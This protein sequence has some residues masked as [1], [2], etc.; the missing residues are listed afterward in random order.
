MEIG[1]DHATLREA[2]KELV[3]GP[4][5]DPDPEVWNKLHPV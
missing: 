2:I 4:R 1:R 5:P 3:T